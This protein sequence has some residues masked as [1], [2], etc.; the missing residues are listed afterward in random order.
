L[1]KDVHIANKNAKI[2]SKLKYKDNKMKEIITYKYYARYVIIVVIIIIIIGRA[3]VRRG[4]R[5]LHSPALY[6]IPNLA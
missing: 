4:R 5:G 6:E 2:S 3:R 1:L